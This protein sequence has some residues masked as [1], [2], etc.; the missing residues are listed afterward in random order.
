M[1]HI[2]PSQPQS[3]GIEWFCGTEPFS[4]EKT[5]NSEK[6]SSCQPKWAVRYPPI[7]GL[8]GCWALRVW[9]P[10]LHVWQTS[11]LLA[12]TPSPWLAS[13]NGLLLRGLAACG[14]RE[15]GIGGGRLELGPV[16]WISPIKHTVVH[17]KDHLPRPAETKGAESNF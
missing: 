2:P 4:T 5:T 3:W 7:S 13:S 1:G 10:S 12:V 9:L 14:N 17:R 11:G 6:T 16:H 8:S 15:V